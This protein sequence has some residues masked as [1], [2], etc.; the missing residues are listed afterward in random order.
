MLKGL[1]KLGAAVAGLGI[2]LDLVKQHEERAAKEAA[3]AKPEEKEETKT[4]T[5]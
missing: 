2:A 5:K 4:E 3:A 1:L